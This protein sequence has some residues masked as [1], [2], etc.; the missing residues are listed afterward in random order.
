MDPLA[1][2]LSLISV[3]LCIAAV[4]LSAISWARI[5]HL[6]LPCP[7]TLPVLSTLTTLVGPVIMAFAV[8]TRKRTLTLVAPYLRYF[9]P[10]LPFA[11]FILSLIYAVPS[12]LLSCSIESQWVSLFRAKNEDAVRGIENALRCCGFNSLH[13]RAWPFP[14]H[15]VDV[16]ACERTLG[17]TRR[18]VDPW[19]NQ[20]QV[21][22]GLLALASLFNWILL[23]LVDAAAQPSPS[24]RFPTASDVRPE[25]TRL[26]REAE[27]DQE[28]SGTGNNHASYSDHSRTN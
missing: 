22:A 27:E 19:R 18:C 14:S 3:V 6:S 26:L 28:Q 1:K 25:Q 2:Y 12:D 5:V 10:F 8:R 17:Y 9:L 4:I 21:A 11:L 23:H 24:R 7:L 13:D 16:T 15:D 20:E